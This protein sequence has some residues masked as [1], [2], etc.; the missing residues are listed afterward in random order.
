M[1]HIRKTPSG[2]WRAIVTLP[3]GKQ[4]SKTDALKKVV[5]L[6]ASNIEADARRGTYHDDRPSK[7]LTLDDWH[8]RWAAT[9]VVSR[10]TQLKNDTHWRVHVQKRFGATPLALITRE[11]VLAWVAG[12]QRQGM[13]AHTIEAVVQLLSKMLADAV[14]IGLLRSNPAARVKKPTTELRVPFYWTVEEAVAIIA[15]LEHP[16]SVMAALA[17]RGG[18][19]MGELRG[20][21]CEQVDLERRLVH[22]TRVETRQGPQDYPKGKKQRVVPIQP[23]LVPELAKLVEGRDPLAY[24][25]AADGERPIDDRNFAQRIFEPARV[26]AGARRG[27]PHD[28]R[29]TAASWLVAD[30][31]DLLRVQ[32]LLGHADTKTT[33]RYA[34]LAPD[35]FDRVTASWGDVSLLPA[36]AALDQ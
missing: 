26:A 30:G 25:F 1:A 17:F 22:V 9:R 36:P 28:M 27:T 24:V 6:W 5:Q 21:R 11:D 3:D 16:W 20:M 14:D 4:R 31:V 18:L 13:G 8:P 15:Q 19:R 34:H 10:N 12:M 7:A 2:K 32:A 29:H 33:L 23:V 35:A